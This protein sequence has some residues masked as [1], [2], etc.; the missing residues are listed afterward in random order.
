MYG[1]ATNLRYATTWSEN[2]LQRHDM[3]GS[4][5]HTGFTT[6]SQGRFV[7]ALSINTVCKRFRSGFTQ[8]IRIVDEPLWTGS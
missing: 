6:R 3:K 8:L 2:G 4:A 5:V 7:N 1:G